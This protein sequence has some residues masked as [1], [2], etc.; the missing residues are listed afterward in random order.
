M[1]QDLELLGRP[2][3]AKL[4]EYQLEDS[5]SLGFSAKNNCRVPVQGWILLVSPCSD[6]CGQWF[7]FHSSVNIYFK[8]ERKILRKFPTDS[9]IV[10]SGNSARTKE[11]W[12][13]CSRVFPFRSSKGGSEHDFTLLACLTLCQQIK[14]HGTDGAAAVEVSTDFKSHPK[15]MCVRGGPESLIKYQQ[16]PRGDWEAREMLGT[17]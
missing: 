11:L 3:K 17:R 12:N 16:V 9:D 5:S 14:R 10:S 2:G 7:A 8:A 13:L 15:V 4:M 6:K 1:L